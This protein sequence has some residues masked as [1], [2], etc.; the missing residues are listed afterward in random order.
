[1]NKKFFHIGITVSDLDA[2]IFFFTE[3][4]DCKLVTKRELKGDYLAKALGNTAIKSATIALLELT[5]GPILELVEYNRVI[6]KSYDSTQHN[7]V[8][9]LAHFVKDIENT[10]NK[11]L[12][13]GCTYLGDP[14]VRIPSG[15]YSDCRIIFLKSQFNVTLEL[16][17]KSDAQ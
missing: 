12:Q 11:L 9:H 3:G 6:D 2:A 1:M 13:L 16:I 8:H 5:H 17:E 10:V 14:D 7:G 4:L 15:P